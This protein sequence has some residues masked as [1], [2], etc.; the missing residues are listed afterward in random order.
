[1]NLA[2]AL[3]VA[4]LALILALMPDLPDRQALADAFQIGWKVDG[5]TVRCHAIGG[6]RVGKSSWVFATT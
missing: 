2:R 3:G 1:M 6:R 4:E 5:D